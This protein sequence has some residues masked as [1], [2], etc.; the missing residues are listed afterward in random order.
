MA[1]VIRK[2]QADLD[3]LEQAKPYVRAGLATIYVLI[4]LARTGVGQSADS[5][6]YYFADSVLEMLE[7]D[8]KDQG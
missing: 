1:K 5:E 4:K 2:N 7:A 6:A 8:V 3:A